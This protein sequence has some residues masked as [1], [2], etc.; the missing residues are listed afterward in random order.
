MAKYYWN[1]E[2]NSIERREDPI[3]RI[4]RDLKDQQRIDEKMLLLYGEKQHLLAKY[5]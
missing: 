3:I 2:T 4:A 1:P 5:A